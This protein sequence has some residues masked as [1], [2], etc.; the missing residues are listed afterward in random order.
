MRIQRLFETENLDLSK[1]IRMCQN[2]EAMAN[3]CNA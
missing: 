3:D 2:V 1:A